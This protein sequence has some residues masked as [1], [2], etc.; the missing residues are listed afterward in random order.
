MKA[1][2]LC[3]LV[4]TE[5]WISVQKTFTVAIPYDFVAGVHPL[6]TAAQGVIAE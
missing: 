6:S 1:K 3:G 2:M 5:W 4:K